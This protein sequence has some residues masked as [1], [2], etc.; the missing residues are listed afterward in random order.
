MAAQNGYANPD[1]L[2]STQ[3]VADHLNDPQVRLV[4]VD[5]DTSA[6]ESGHIRNAVGWN[7]QTQL[8]DRIVR[9]I[10]TKESWEQLL[11][12]SGISN[13]TKIIFYGD[14]NNWFA[15]FAYWIAKMYGHDNVALMNGGRK[16][17]ELEGR[18]FTTEAPSVRRTEY[19]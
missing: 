9:D 6:Y 10:P 11:G 13:D 14:N 17:W 7:W 12:E 3:W 19:P 1:A 2:V 4:E 16:K 5:V 15:A 18:A 8:S